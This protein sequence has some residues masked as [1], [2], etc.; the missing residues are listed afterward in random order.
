MQLR[1]IEGA[2]WSAVSEVLHLAGPAGSVRFRR[3]RSAQSRYSI[4]VG[5]VPVEA[6]EYSV[7][8]AVVGEEAAGRRKDLLPIAGRIV[9][10]HGSDLVRGGC[11]AARSWTAPSAA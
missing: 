5:A 4:V 1:R 11:V 6:L 7:R 10:G 2:P 9:E 3:R 8:A